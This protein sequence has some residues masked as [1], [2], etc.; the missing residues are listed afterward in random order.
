MGR[1]D[2]ALLRMARSGGGLIFQDSGPVRIKGLCTAFAIGRAIGGA[3]WIAGSAPRPRDLIF[4]QFAAA[5][6]KRHA[7]NDSSNGTGA[8]RQTALPA[9]A[10]T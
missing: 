6:W 5:A 7:G 1:R 9:K 2:A 8:E 4:E 10:E 3:A